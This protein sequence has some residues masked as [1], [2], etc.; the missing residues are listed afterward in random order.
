M[1]AK[2]ATRHTGSSTTPTRAEKPHTIEQIEQRQR[3]VRS[4]EIDAMNVLIRVLR[5]LAVAL[6]IESKMTFDLADAA[7]R[8]EKD[9]ASLVRAPEHG[10]PVVC[11]GNVLYALE[12]EISEEIRRSKPEEES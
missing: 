7:K 10:K 5:D 1:P 4:I 8:L 12:R 3:V 2:K 11:T 6:P 9:V